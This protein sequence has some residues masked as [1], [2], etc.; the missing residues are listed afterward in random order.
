MDAN[1]EAERPIEREHVLTL[2]TGGGQKY[3]TEVDDDGFHIYR[4]KK[5]RAGDRQPPQSLREAN[6]REVEAI[7][8]LNETNREFWSGAR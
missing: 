1:R 5:A 4:R 6:D 3:D 2:P 8:A 7:A